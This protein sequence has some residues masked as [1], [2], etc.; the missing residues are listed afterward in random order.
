MSQAK[1]RTSTAQSAEDQ[2]RDYILA[3]GLGPGDP[4]PTELELCNKLGFSRS[5]VREAV[6][7]LAALDIVEVR[8]GTG[9]FVGHLSLMPMV[10][11]LAFRSVVAPGEANQALR[12][13]VEVRTALDLGQAELVVQQLVGTPQPDLE[14][15]V[16]EMVALS[17]QGKGF[18]EQDRAFHSRLLAHT[19][20]QL[21][22]SLVEAFWDVH[23][24][25]LAKLAVPTPQDITATARAHGDMLHAAE[26][27]D[28]I[29]YR[30]A[31]RA[32]FA[33]L[34]RVLDRPVAQRTKGPADH[35]V[36]S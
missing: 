36:K 34:L 22:S 35:A 19:P 29:A 2:I 27:G 13:I 26:S 4:M 30:A 11:S 10:Q 25:L 18:T 24:I 32:H 1:R 15:L 31:V 23:S 28:V 8:H 5:S 16:V 17:E 12:E 33:P 3:Q 7:T 14:Q 9:T 6:R 20:N 21:M